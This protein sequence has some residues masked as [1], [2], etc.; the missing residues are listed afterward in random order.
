MWR[1]SK[2]K[3]DALVNGEPKTQTECYLHDSVSLGEVEQQ[4]A[5]HLRVRI[6]NP[7]VDAAAKVKYAQVIFFPMQ[8][9]DAFYEVKTLEY[10]EGKKYTSTYLLPALT[11][12]EAEQR[13]KDHYKNMVIPWEIVAVKK[14]DIMAVWH[15]HNEIWKG[16]WHNRMERYADEGKQEAGYNQMDMFNS[17]GTAAQSDDEQPKSENTTTTLVKATPLDVLIQNGVQAVEAEDLDNG[18]PDDAPTETLSPVLALP[19]GKQ[20]P[21]ADQ[22][23]EPSFP[24]DLPEN[25]APKPDTNIEPDDDGRPAKKKK[26]GKA[27]NGKNIT[28]RNKKGEP[29]GS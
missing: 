25:P 9:E 29:V 20:E 10:I 19:E 4:C 13:L 26:T 23:S 12:I 8:D 15:P 24:D 11:T 5:E 6:K 28:F 17:D 22:P 1:K 14:S 2:I 7:D 21:E 27:P 3:Y 16:D 18:T